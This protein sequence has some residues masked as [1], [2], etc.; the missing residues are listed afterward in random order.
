VTKRHKKNVEKQRQHFL[1]AFWILGHRNS[2][3][4]GNHKKRVGGL[5]PKKI[6]FLPKKRFAC[7]MPKRQHP[8]KRFS[9]TP[10]TPQTV[11]LTH[12]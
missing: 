5:I 4:P 7:I 2:R 3:N 11:C 12:A 1:G 10:E 8:L 6:K 9:E